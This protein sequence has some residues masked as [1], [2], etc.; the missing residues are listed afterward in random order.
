MQAKATSIAYLL[1]LI[2]QPIW[3]WLLPG[4]AGYQSIWL[5]G[6]LGLPLLLPL[7]GILKGSLRK[8]IVGAYIS[9]PHFMF[10]ISEAWANPAGRWLA[11]GQLGLII[12]Y[13]VLLIQRGRRRKAERME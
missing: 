3:L 13:W 12:L 11:L 7:A 10:A 6:I 8:G 4:P 9:T 2:L 1:L 5:A